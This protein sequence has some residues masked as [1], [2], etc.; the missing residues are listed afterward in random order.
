MALALDVV[1]NPDLECLASVNAG[2]SLSLADHVLVSE[3]RLELH[4]N[5]PV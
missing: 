2:T 3:G 1:T 5:A 4:V